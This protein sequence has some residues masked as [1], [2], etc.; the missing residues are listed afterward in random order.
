MAEFLQVS[1]ILFGIILIVIEYIK[2]EK[3]TASKINKGRIKRTIV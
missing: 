1:I 3:I 2:N